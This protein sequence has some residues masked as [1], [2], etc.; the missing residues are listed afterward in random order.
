M[1]IRCKKVILTV[2]ILFVLLVIGGNKSGFH[3]DEMYTF[4][5]SNHQFD[6]KVRPTI[7]PNKIYTGEQLWQEYTTV[8]PEHTFDY[9][10]VFRNQ[11]E[12]VHPPLY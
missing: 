1:K 8:S 6:G 10:N 12:D 2:L 4:G 3:V 11:A 9:K 5:L 7:I